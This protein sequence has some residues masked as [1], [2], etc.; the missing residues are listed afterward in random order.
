[1]AA[2]SVRNWSA[3]TS[4]E[5]AAVWVTATEQTPANILIQAA[6]PLAVIMK[7]AAIQTA[8]MV[9]EPVRASLLPATTM[10]RAP[11]KRFAAV[12]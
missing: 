12:I 2:A 7:T 9:P 6:K 3:K 5:P 1:M 8:A 11:T 4:L 10:V